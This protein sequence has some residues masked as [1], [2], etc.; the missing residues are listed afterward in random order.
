[1]PSKNGEESFAD[2]NPIWGWYFPGNIHENSRIEGI[3]TR[4]D[5]SG[6]L[7]MYKIIRSKTFLIFNV[8]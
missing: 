2:L 8:L 4:D 6:K 7:D 5:T 1:V 3:V